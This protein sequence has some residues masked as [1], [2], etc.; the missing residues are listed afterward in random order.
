MDL[1]LVN[2][3]DSEQLS[4]IKAN[5]APRDLYNVENSR[6]DPTLVF[7]S[8]AGNTSL[9]DTTLRGLK[10]P[11]ELDGN[12]SLVVSSGYDRI[13]EQII[14]TLETRFSER[15][16]RPYMGTPEL[17]FETISESLLANT[18]KSQILSSVPLLSSDGLRITIRINENG[19]CVVIVVYSV[20][21]SEEAMV[22]YLYSA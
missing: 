4:R 7:G 16:Y 14:E 3:I 20:E 1:Q 6:P 19:D 22:R 2:R 13:A 15:V 12:G 8:S 11:L 17:M 10:Y 21:G 5:F 18:L 9:T